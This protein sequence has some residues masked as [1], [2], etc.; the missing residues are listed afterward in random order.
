MHPRTVGIVVAGILVFALGMRFAVF[1]YGLLPVSEEV[2][3][4]KAVALSVGYTLDGN[5]RKSLTITNPDQVEEILSLMELRR[6][7]FRDE[8]RKGGPGAV[9]GT[10]DLTFHFHDR[11]T[12]TLAFEA[13]DWLGQYRVNPR[14]YERLR[15]I[16]S[17]SERKRIELLDQRPFRGAEKW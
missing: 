9:P 4:K 14:F 8:W 10:A 3:L 7:T 5:N 16:V 11:S 12:R 15:E 1:H 13:R 17:L 6:E 2:V